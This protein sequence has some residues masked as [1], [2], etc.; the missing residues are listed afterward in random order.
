M[1]LGAV[2]GKGKNDKDVKGKG[3]GELMQAEKEK[4][5]AKLA[6]KNEDE[7]CFHCEKKGHVKS[8]CRNR[9]RDMKNTVYPRSLLT[10]EQQ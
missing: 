10:Q 5:D 6:E 1:Q 4:D 8:D 2:K 7:Q 9:Q 3:K